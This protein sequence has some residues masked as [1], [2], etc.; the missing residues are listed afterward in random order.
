MQCSEIFTSLESPPKLYDSSFPWVLFLG[1]ALTHL[2]P[3]P[4]GRM[5]QTGLEEGMNNGGKTSIEIKYFAN[6]TDLYYLLSYP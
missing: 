4:I 1:A 3:E 2:G 6:I 5:N